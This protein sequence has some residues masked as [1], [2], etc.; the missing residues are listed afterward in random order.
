[1]HFHNR[2]INTKVACHIKIVIYRRKNKHN[3]HTIKCLLFSDSM[4][5]VDCFTEDLNDAGKCDL[6]VNLIRFVTLQIYVFCIG[7]KLKRHLILVDDT[8]RR[9]VIE[10][11]H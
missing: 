5:S 4:N 3:A 7:L 10:V 2:L 11:S 6:L 1:M 8:M 9:Q